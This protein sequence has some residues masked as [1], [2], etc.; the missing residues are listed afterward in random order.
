V[1]VG[2][3]W[4]GI[5]GKQEE[6]EDGTTVTVDDAYITESI[7]EPNLKV[8]KGFAPVMLDFTDQITDEQVADIIEFIKSLK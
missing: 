2:P 6:L 5:Y 1:I 8:T 7:H 4:K 3:S